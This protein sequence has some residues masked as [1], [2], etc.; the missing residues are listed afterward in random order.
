MT[1]LH[2]IKDSDDS[3]HLNLSCPKVS[4]K[5]FNDLI[6]QKLNFATNVTLDEIKFAVLIICVQILK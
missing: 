5:C 4:L 3:I 2:F 6:H 1:S